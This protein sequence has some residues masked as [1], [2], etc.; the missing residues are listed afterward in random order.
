LVAVIVKAWLDGHSIDLETLAGLLPAGDTRV[1]RDGDGFYL[2]GDEIDN[3]AAG[4]P[5]YE[6]APVVLQRVNGLARVMRSGY[7][8]VRLSGRYQEGD[9]R[10]QVVQAGCAKIRVQAMPVT[11]LINGEPV[12]SPLPPG[13]GY[14]A[15]ASADAEIAEALAILGQPA[16]PNWVELYK[17]YEIIEHTGLLK[18]AMGA[19]GVSGNQLSVFTRTACHPAAAGP[20][21]RH[22]RS[23]QDPP[24]H[25]MPIAK[26]RELIS[27]LVRAWM[28]LRAEEPT[29][30]TR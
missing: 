29:P 24:K 3:R 2:T 12:A 5:F 14:S 20:D 6:V 13:P 8:P 7:R 22:G 9:R 19:A 18:A 11:I 25:P 26:A 15:T 30:A 17:V 23:R 16:A 10:H 28:D 21:A 1:V 4:V 27:G